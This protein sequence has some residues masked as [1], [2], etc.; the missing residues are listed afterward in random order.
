MT[1]HLIFITLGTLLIEHAS[2]IVNK[3]L[4]FLHFPQKL[5]RIFPSIQTYRYEYMYR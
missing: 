2:Q 4:E 3:H 1:S 5:W